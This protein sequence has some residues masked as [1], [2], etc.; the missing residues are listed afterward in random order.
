MRNLKILF[1]FPLMGILLSFVFISEARAFDME[2]AVGIWRQDP[3]GNFSLDG[4]TLEGDSLDIEDDLKYDRDDNLI[5]R[6]RLDLPG[7]FPNVYLMATKVEFEE[8]GRREEPFRFGNEVFQGSFESRLKYDHY[9]ISVF[10]S[11]PLI[12]TASLNRL[13]FDLGLNGRVVDLQAEVSQSGRTERED[14]TAF[15]PMLFAAAQARPFK[16]LSI[17]GE[18]RGL[19]IS[20]QHLL[21]IIGRVKVKPT[22][23]LFIA[24]GYRFEDIE[25]DQSGIAADFTIEGPFAEAGVEF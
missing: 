7:L 9:D 11:I 17:E 3:S 21:D 5:A 18:L 6:V 23:F 8:T 12:K 15:V 16:F 13:N 19:A 22:A 1:F 4:D 14:L 10:Y 25:V 20:S 2:G 24:G